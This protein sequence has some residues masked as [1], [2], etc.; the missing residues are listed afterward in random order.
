MINTIASGAGPTG[1]LRL[2]ALN[3]RIAG[4]QILAGIDLAVAPGECLA[5]LGPSGCGKSTILRLIAGLDRPDG[6]RI[7]LAGRD[8]TAL[9]PGRRQVAMVFQ[10]YALYPHLSVERNL[11][12]GMELR[13]VPRQQ[14]QQEADRVLSMLQLE[15]FRSRRPSELS[16]GQRQRVAL[17]RA[18]LRR[19]QVFLLDEPMSNLDAQL[20]D[21]LRAELRTLLRSTGVPVVYVTHDQQ[22]AMGIADRIAVLQNGRL[23]QCGTPQELYAN[24]ANVVV[25]SFIGRPQINLLDRGD[26]SLLGIR[27]EHLQ[28]VEDGGV[29]VRV[30][31]R[32]WHGASQQLTVASP[33]GDLRWTTSGAEPIN[34]QLRL[35]WQLQHELRFDLATGLRC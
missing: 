5:L 27:P 2:E 24:P 18:L 29:A 21:N 7:L 8:I 34:D 6:G 3:R 19:P 9:P 10:S 32:E 1:D 25:A 11:L 17:A 12:L 13:G 4:R 31:S 14:R 26:G 33:H 20:R 15:S 23:Q 30:L 35:G 16:G 22:E 28:A